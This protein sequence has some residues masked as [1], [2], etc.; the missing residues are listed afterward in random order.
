M[1]L[2]FE[3]AVFDE[4]FPCA[5]TLYHALVCI[6]FRPQPL[7]HTPEELLRY[8]LMK[9]AILIIHA[10]G[11]KF[12]FPSL[13]K[14]IKKQFPRLLILAHTIVENSAYKNSLLKSGSSAIVSGKYDLADITES[15]DKLV[16][17]LA[18][19]LPVNNPIRKFESDVPLIKIMQLMAKG[20]SAKEIAHLTDMKEAEVEARKKKI[21]QI[22]GSSNSVEAIAKLKDNRVI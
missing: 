12:D 4:C 6:G 1:E 22:T 5:Q 13:I 19:D 15:I 11:S 3:I 14:Q 2:S 16:P 21:I 10:D 7:S 20:K 8:L 9:P 17:G 18:I